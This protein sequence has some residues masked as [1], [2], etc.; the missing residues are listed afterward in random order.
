MNGLGTYQRLDLNGLQRSFPPKDPLVFVQY[1]GPLSPHS[2][3][4]AM[5]EAIETFSVEMYNSLCAPCK[6]Q[7]DAGYC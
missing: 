4:A 1:V 7:T 2:R 6:S 3:S 5:V